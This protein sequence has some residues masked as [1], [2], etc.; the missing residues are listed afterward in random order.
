[1]RRPSAHEKG[2]ISDSLLAY[3]SSDRS[4]GGKPFAIPL[5]HEVN[6]IKSRGQLQQLFSA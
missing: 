1:M 4:A 5:T 6:L 2:A 3:V